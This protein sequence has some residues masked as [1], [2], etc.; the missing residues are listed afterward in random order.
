MYFF[1]GKA[2]LGSLF[3]ENSL[4]RSLTISDALVSGVLLPAHRDATLRSPTDALATRC[5]FG[6]VR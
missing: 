3:F 2:L 4:F 1:M 6:I 5:V